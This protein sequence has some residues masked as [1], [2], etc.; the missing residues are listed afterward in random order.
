MD[1]NIITIHY[2]PFAFL[3]NSIENN[4]SLFKKENIN[5]KHYLVDNKYPLE[6]EQQKKIKKLCEDYNIVYLNGET[7]LGLVGGKNYFH[8]QIKPKD[9]IFHMESDVFLL[10][11]NI[12]TNI[13]KLN[14]HNDIGNV[15]YLNNKNLNDY[16][17]KIYK[18]NDINVFELDIKNLNHT[19]IQCCFYNTNYQNKIQ[20]ILD[21]DGR[22]NYDFPGE[23]S[24]SFK[25]EN[26][27]FL[28]INDF[29]EDMEKYRFQNY[30]EYE[31]YK[32]IVYYW[33]KFEEEFKSLTFESFVNNYD[34]YCDMDE[35]F[36]ACC[37]NFKNRAKE[38]V[39]I[40]NF[41]FK[42]TKIKFN[43]IN[44][45]FIVNK[46]KIDKYEKREIMKSIKIKE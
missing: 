36:S 42:K 32:A 4:Y 26:I 41:Y 14:E 27:P 40:P 15:I 12:L 24:A 39:I 43:Y 34:Y 19:W 37:I 45:N 21:D 29:Y 28:V 20:K 30:F 2:H 18:I 10:T 13:H 33:S 25:K 5:F 35:K 3:K 31:Y 8:E 16:E 7:N 22:N 9:I 23:N 38:H 46:N 6:R 1:I 11:E 17:K 44:T